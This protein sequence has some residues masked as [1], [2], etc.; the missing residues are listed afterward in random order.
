V[1]EQAVPPNKAGNQAGPPKLP[2]IISQIRKLAATR[3]DDEVYRHIAMDGTERAGF[4][5]FGMERHRFLPRE[6]GVIYDL[7]VAP[8]Y[9]KKG[10]A[11]RCAG[12]AIAEL[13]SLGPRKIQLETVEGN[14]N[15]RALWSSLGFEK[16]ADRFV[17][18]EGGR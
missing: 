11:H 7:Y 16:V 4:I 13:R 9:R 8:E 15:A 3:G 10:I 14:G 6:T 1:T 5:L 12:Q 17:L 2:S 18:Q